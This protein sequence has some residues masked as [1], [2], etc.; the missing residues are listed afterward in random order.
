MIEL[1]MAF[2][3][4]GYEFRITYCDGHYELD[5]W[6]P[7]WKTMPLMAAS[8]YKGKDLM[9]LFDSILAPTKA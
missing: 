6:K 1:F 2:I 5:I 7:E 3:K 9:E 4:L 8:T